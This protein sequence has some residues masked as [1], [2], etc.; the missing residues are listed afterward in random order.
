MKGLNECAVK[1]LGPIVDRFVDGASQITAR[2][3]EELATECA[4]KCRPAKPR[5]FVSAPIDKHQ[6]VEDVAALP[7]HFQEVITFHNIVTRAP[8]IDHVATLAESG[9]AF[10]QRRI[11][12]V[13]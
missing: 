5:D 8:D 9:C 4:A 13:I 3:A 1:R 12:T 2:Y 10:D 11:K 7:R 6:A